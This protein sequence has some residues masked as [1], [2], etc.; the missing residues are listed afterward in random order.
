[1]DVGAYKAAGLSDELPHFHFVAFL[2][3]GFGRRTEVLRHIY[4]SLIRER[5]LLNTLVVSDFVGFG[6]HTSHVEGFLS[7]GFHF[8]LGF[9]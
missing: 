3:D 9:G 1:M 6:M 8:F 4:H 5:E 2:N 7:Q